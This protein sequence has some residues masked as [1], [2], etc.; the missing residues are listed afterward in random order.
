MGNKA[1]SV[2]T[3]NPGTNPRIPALSTKLQPIEIHDTYIQGAY[4]YNPAQDA[5]TGGG[6]KTAGSVG[7]SAQDAPAFNSIHD[8]Q[9][10]G[11]V[12]YGIQFAAGHDNIAANNR[13]ISSGLLSDGTKIRCPGRRSGQR[14]TCRGKRKY[15]Q[16]YDARQ[17]GRLDLLEILLPQT[18]YLK[19]QFFP[20]SP[21]DYSTNS[22]V[23]TPQITF[24]MENNEYQVWLNKL[25][26]AAV[27]VGR[28]SSLPQ[29]APRSGAAETRLFEGAASPDSIPRL[30]FCE[31]FLVYASKTSLVTRIWLRISNCPQQTASQTAT[32]RGNAGEGSAGSSTPQQPLPQSTTIFDRPVPGISLHKKFM[33]TY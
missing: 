18:G 13:V 33:E 27:S 19:D 11:T 10:V 31:P 20:A 14:R 21:A 29:A 28:S 15:V 5:Y 6:T 3:E 16:Q 8:N 23:P 2:A 12:N 25:S 4:P 32:S 9:V 24:N 22:V 30:F 17:P 7:D 1:Y 26:A